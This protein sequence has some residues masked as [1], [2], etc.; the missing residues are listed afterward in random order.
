MQP[1]NGTL[2]QE[3]AFPRGAV[4]TSVQAVKAALHRF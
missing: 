2:I 4:L 3:S 1:Y